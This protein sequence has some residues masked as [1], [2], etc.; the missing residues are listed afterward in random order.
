[1]YAA[2]G[3]AQVQNM[4][5][6]MQPETET[7]FDDQDYAIVTVFETNLNV[8]LRAYK[9]E[10]QN[11]VDQSVVYQIPFDDGL[12]FYAVQ[13]PVAKRSLDASAN[14]NV[15]PNSS[16]YFEWNTDGTII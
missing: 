16:P 3:P 4:G 6:Y 2:T 9:N 10:D 8:P 12:Q 5:E 1:M 14:L 13:K 7:D 15:A 11:K